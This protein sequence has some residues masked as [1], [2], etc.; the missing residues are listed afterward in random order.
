MGK[1]G[2]DSSLSGVDAQR[3][4]LDELMGANRN[5]DNPDAI[6]TDFKDDVSAAQE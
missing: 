4:M 3:A 5:L 1:W 6:V 2:R